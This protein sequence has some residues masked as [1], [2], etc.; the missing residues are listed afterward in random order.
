MLVR[1]LSHGNVVGFLSLLHLKHEGRERQLVIDVAA[2]CQ[3]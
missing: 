3:A 1:E 2:E